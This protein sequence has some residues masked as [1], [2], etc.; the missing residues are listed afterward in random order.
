MLA[1]AIHHQPVPAPGWPAMTMTFKAPDA[2]MTT[3][4]QKG[5]AVEFS[6]RE[7]GSEHVLTE[8]KPR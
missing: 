7:Q 3:G 5:A 8:I 6:F 2:G 4:L 1:F